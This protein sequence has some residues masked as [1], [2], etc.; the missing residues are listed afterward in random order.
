MNKQTDDNISLEQAKKIA[1]NMPDL[2]YLKPL[3]PKLI[4]VEARER[5]DETDSNKHSGYS[6]KRKAGLIEWKPGQSGNPLGRPK[7]QDTITSLV[8]DILD[9]T[10]DKTNKTYAQLVAEAMVKGALKDPQILKELL[11][12]CEGKV[13]ESI[14]MQTQGISI[15]YELVRGREDKGGDDAI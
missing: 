2:S 8:K 3:I 14:D 10:D 13:T 11:N 9:K 5:M 15:L 1:Q 6:A 4:E 12:R 7:K